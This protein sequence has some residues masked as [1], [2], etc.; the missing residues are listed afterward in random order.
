MPLALP[1][2][3]IPL[4]NEVAK[5]TAGPLRHALV[6]E[7]RAAIHATGSLGLDLLNVLC[8]KDLFEVTNPIGD[9]PLWQVCSVQVHE[10]TLR[11]C[12]ER[13]V[14][15]FL[16]SGALH[17]H[18]DVLDVQSTSAEDVTSR[19]QPRKLSLAR[20]LP[21]KIVGQAAENSAAL[22]P[23]SQNRIPELLGEHPDELVGPG[24]PSLKQLRRQGAVSVLFVC[25]EQPLQVLDVCWVRLMTFGWLHTRDL[26]ARRQHFLLE[27]LLW[28]PDPGHSTAHASCKVVTNWS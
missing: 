25:L 24:R 21:R 1:H 4:W 5:W 28:I 2:Q 26:D 20:T 6:A 10:S 13:H 27:L 14:L 23:S 7:G 19:A 11:L 9:G 18:V 15:H 17:E 12:D 22:R 8:R 3:I 16:G